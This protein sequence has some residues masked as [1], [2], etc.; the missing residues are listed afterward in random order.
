MPEVK[1]SETEKWTS[2][3]SLIPPVFLKSTSETGSLLQVMDRQSSSE[4]EGDL[5]EG[6]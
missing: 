2:R 4:S 5:D 6:R 1:K 3:E